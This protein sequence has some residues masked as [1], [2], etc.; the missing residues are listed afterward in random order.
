M[1]WRSY[2]WP[3]RLS[4]PSSR[5]SASGVLLSRKFSLVNQPAGYLLPYWMA[6]Y[7]GFVTADQ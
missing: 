4:K 1:P 5:S 2:S 7:Y 3:G 6:R